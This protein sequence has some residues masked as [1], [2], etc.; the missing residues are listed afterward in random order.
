M[1]EIVQQAQPQLKTGIDAVWLVYRAFQLREEWKEPNHN[2]MA[3][4][5]KLAGLGLGVGSIAGRAFPGMKLPDP[6][7]NGLN[8][9]LKAGGS[10]VEGKTIPINELILSTEKRQ[11]I[12]LKIFKVAGISLDPTPP[13]VGAPMAPLPRTLVS[14]LSKPSV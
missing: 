9:F 10:L 1:G 6:W 14:P 11:A 2:T 12:P 4:L 13:M 3:C 5:L 8:F 7:S